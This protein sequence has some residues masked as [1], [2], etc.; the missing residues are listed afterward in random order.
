[1]Q[2]A[3]LTVISWHWQYWRRWLGAET[4]DCRRRSG[5]GY[6]ARLLCTL[7]VW[8]RARTLLRPAT[9]P[10]PLARCRLVHLL[11]AAVQST[12]TTTYRRVYFK[13]FVGLHNTPLSSPPIPSAPISSPPLPLEVGPLNPARGSG[14]RCKLPQRDLGRSPSQILDFGA[15]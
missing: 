3:T 15:F 2:F 7:T 9:A 13:D 10:V 6:A 4:C 11:A 12:H 1:M 8:A 14:E 5:R